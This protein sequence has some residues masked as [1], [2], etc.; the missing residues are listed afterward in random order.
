VNGEF[1][2][3]SKFWG[4]T[5]NVFPAGKMELYLATT[6]EHYVW[7]KAALSIHNLVLGQM[8]LDFYGDIQIKNVDTGDCAKVKLIKARGYGLD[9]G[10]LEGK[11]LDSSKKE[12]YSIDGNYSKVI[13]ARKYPHNNRDEIFRAADL[14]N[15]SEEQYNMTPFAVGL[16]DLDGLEEEELPRTDSRFRP[17]VRNLE[18]GD[19]ALASREKLRLEEKQRN[20]RKA[21][22]ANGQKYV[23]MWFNLRKP[24]VRDVS[25]AIEQ[26]Q[27]LVWK[28][29][30]EYWERKE[31]GNWGG[32]PDIY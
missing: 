2:L 7:N 14:P 28:F 13:Y 23:P 11:I 16:N 15:N 26:D 20:M 31:M 10:T 29:R 9:R 12:V 27:D 3:K 4:T 5:V 19:L 25:R 24:D 18:N 17:D 6:N 21:R 32:C 22:K 1:E 30:E 8:W